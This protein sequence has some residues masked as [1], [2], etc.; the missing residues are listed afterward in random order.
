M[1]AWAA[2]VTLRNS[3]V[4]AQ[5]Q[6][7][8]ILVLKERQK[9]AALQKD[10]EESQKWYEVWPSQPDSA[11]ECRSLS[12]ARFCLRRLHDALNSK[13][14][15]D[16]EHDTQQKRVRLNIGGQVF[17][18][19]LA[20]LTREKGS[21]LARV[22]ERFVGEID[23][24]LASARAAAESSQAPKEDNS[25][26]AVS[27][28][29]A[30]VPTLQLNSQ[31]TAQMLQ[32]AGNAVDPPFFDRDWWLFR[33]L[34]Q[35]LR[36]GPAALPQDPPLL[37]QLF[38]EAA[39]WRLTEM[40]EHMRT[41]YMRVA[42]RQAESEASLANTSAHSMPMSSQDMGTHALLAT[43]MS[44]AAA[45]QAQQQPPLASTWQG[46]MTQQQ[47]QHNAQRAGQHAQP[48]QPV[49]G[50]APGALRPG[51]GGPGVPAGG[52]LLPPQQ[53]PHWNFSNSQP[54]PASSQMNYAAGQPSGLAAKAAL[55]GFGAG[56]PS[57]PQPGSFGSSQGMQGATA[58]VHYPPYSLPTDAAAHAASYAASAAQ[59]QFQSQ[60][61]TPAGGQAA[62]AGLATSAGWPA[63]SAMAASYGMGS[64]FGGGGVSTPG[65][66][67]GRAILM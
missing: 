60:P 65:A 13:W 46:G 45:T 17:E 26:N 41:L 6:Q 5:I 37:K 39:F 63:S 8:R 25:S 55:V 28:V 50:P 19:T 61:P 12:P 31:H 24:A 47:Y 33:Y 42:A 30:M 54:W 21:K 53:S 40:Q 29:D 44:R 51:F 22:A 11:Q 1:F 18:T 52:A 14:M 4:R 20:V 49:E 9:N 3:N 2:G 59:R 7:E 48:W 34:L 27:E 15:E 58:Q 23:E 10:L 32:D 62:S 16:A 43:A 35:A 64:T 36:E 57:Q 66:P 67:P 38:D 56:A